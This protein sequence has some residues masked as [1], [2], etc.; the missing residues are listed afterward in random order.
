MWKSQI[1]YINIFLKT[2]NFYFL[3]WLYKK[4][5]IIYLLFYLIILLKMTIKQEIYRN[6]W[7]LKIRSEFWKLISEKL[8]KDLLYNDNDFDKNDFYELDIN[9]NLNKNIDVI[10][11]L[12]NFVK[13]IHKVDPNANITW[14]ITLDY[15][16]PNY[17]DPNHNMENW[18][19]E[20]YW[21]NYKWKIESFNNLKDV[22]NFVNPKINN[23]KVKHW[24]K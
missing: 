1:Y 13:T 14:F 23:I 2:N 3:S 6:W 18:D 21:I 7:S 22:E 20:Y 15:K 17:E 10:E 11:Q 9:F 12:E 4:I 19:F 16:Y 5:Y 24:L 8:K